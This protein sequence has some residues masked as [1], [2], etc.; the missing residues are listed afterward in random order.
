MAVRH[1][2]LFKD[3][4]TTASDWHRLRSW[5]RHLP[6][7][8]WLFVL[9]GFLFWVAYFTLISIVW[10]AYNTW[11]VPL[12]APSWP[13]SS[14][15][16]L[17]WQVLNLTNFA[18][19]LLMIFRTNS[20][21]ARW[22]EA[23]TAWGLIIALA[24]NLVR[25]AAAWFPPKE[26][27]ALEMVGRLTAALPYALRVHLL[28]AE[29]DY[30]LHPQDLPADLKVVLTPEEATWVLR[31]RHRPMAAAQLLADCVAAVEVTPIQRTA[32]DMVI[33]EYVRLMG[34]CERIERT[35]IPAAYTRHTSRFLIVWLT[36]LPFSLWEVYGWASPA[37]QA[38]ISFLLI[39]VE[40][41]GIQ[42]EE[43]FAVLPL[44]AYCDAI[45][46]DVEEVLANTD[47]GRK[48]VARVRAEGA[49]TWPHVH[50]HHMLGLRLTSQSSF[51]LI[52]F[53]PRYR[54]QKR[55]RLCSNVVSEQ[56]T[57]WLQQGGDAVVRDHDAIILLAG[58]LTP[59]GGCPLW[60]KR[61]LDAAMHVQRQQGRPFCVAGEAHH[62][63]SLCWTNT[64]GMFCTSPRFVLIT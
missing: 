27:A 50:R 11:L 34:A 32:L 14:R 20:A 5:R 43:P 31:W 40:N 44:M 1:R 54:Q 39:G 52:T 59:D 17:T 55:R 13:E 36:L 38:I 26:Q 63:N 9:H 42:I 57:T 62:T 16:G 53:S 49:L 48:L 28:E 30:A 4:P 23:R 61:R 24:R 10:G 37:L 58:G 8:T 7:F 6:D 35:A 46:K 12:G 47:G 29:Q 25:Q 60:V 22:W 33:A 51:R 18:L 15:L 45:R 41:I 19:S 56:R 2:L 21:Y 3:K 64:L